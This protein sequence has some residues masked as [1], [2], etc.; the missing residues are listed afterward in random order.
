MAP[1]SG[2]WGTSVPDRGRVDRAA[3]YVL[4]AHPYSET[5]LLV[6]AFTRTHG[7]LPLL[8]KGARRPGSQLRGT[9]LAFQPLS[10]SWSGRGEVRTLVR[11]E[12]HGGQPLLAGERLLCGFYLNEL[13]LRLL[14]REDPHDRLFD[15]Y[16]EAVAG[17]AHSAEAGPVLRAF[18]RGLLAELGYALPLEHE[19]GAATPVE[20]GRLYRYD[21]EH[22]A[23]PVANGG[24]AGADE[25]LVLPGRVLLEI[26]R[27][28][29]AAPDT[30]QAAKQLMRLAIAR[31]LDRQ[32][33][34]SRTIFRELANL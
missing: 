25:A 17:L 19:A 9:L 8:A 27:D 32:P 15:R 16:V 11:C 23:V 28:E 18:E 12:W 4:H 2:G 26:A 30:A 14:P 20:P 10:A 1:R 34:H 33:L 3:A 5:S 29:Y 24:G 13:L 21:L 6:E 7:R 31:R 22:G